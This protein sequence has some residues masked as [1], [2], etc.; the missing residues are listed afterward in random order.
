MANF[1]KLLISREY[2]RL[3]GFALW[4]LCFV[5]SLAVLLVAGLV[6]ARS[7]LRTEAQTELKV[8][9]GLTNNIDAAFRALGSQVTAAPCSN[10]FHSQ[11][12]KVAF[13]PD[14]LHEFIYAPDGI[15]VCSTNVATFPRPEQLQNPDIPATDPEGISIWA[16]HPLDFVGLKGLEGSIAY[17]AP[18]AI[19]VPMPKVEAI[20]DWVS[21]E[22]VLVAPDGRTWHRG[23]ELG[24][25]DGHGRDVAQNGS[26]IVADVSMRETACEEGGIYCI[27][28][29]TT[30][31]RVLRAS[32][33]WI[34]VAILFASVL[35]ALLGTH[36]KSLLARYWSF[37]A[38][39]LRN[40]K[41]D[42]VICF[43]QPILN[44]RS[45]EIAGVEV[46]ARWRDVDGTVVSPDKFID[47][48]SRAGLTKDFTQMVANRAYLELAAILPPSQRLQ[49]NFN[50]FPG[51]LDCAALCH[52]FRGFLEEQHRFDLVLEIVESDALPI[53]IVQ[54]EIEALGKTGIKVYIDD[55]GTGYSNIQN[56]ALLAIH[57]V[58][59]DRS[60]GMAPDKSMMARMLLHAID[61]V[62]T[63]GCVIVVEGVET[64]ERLELLRRTKRV[65]FAQGYYISRPLPAGALVEF[66]G[67]DSE[68]PVAHVRAA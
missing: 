62:D 63:S 47:I 7:A 39:F 20:H 32:E 36:A 30:P 28:A 64:C 61:M 42:S 40:L 66:L 6:Q 48:V 17:K 34:A 52:T 37:E 23:G 21:K 65:D 57:G 5:V 27:T 33:K 16:R 1:T 25:H 54:R 2:E 18:F 22:L 43:Y 12:K 38:R 13:L 44:V 11:L 58:K 3:T 68:A 15:P 4:S 35:A 50:I 9:R 26:A 31:L 41:P 14:G 24:V 19:I 49:V 59:L 55:F 10:E 46:L 45:G 60:F 29:G 53:D 8:L 56:L 51:D 67:R